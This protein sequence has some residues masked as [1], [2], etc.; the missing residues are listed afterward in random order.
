M[1]SYRILFPGSR[2]QMSVTKSVMLHQEADATASQSRIDV[3][4]PGVVPCPVYAGAH[5]A[6]GYP[7]LKLPGLS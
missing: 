5:K 1:R 6:K 7:N 2:L 3:P 4:L